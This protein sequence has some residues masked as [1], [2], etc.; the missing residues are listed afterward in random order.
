MHNGIIHI[1][2]NRGQESDGYYL[3]GNHK[4]IFIEANPFVMPT[5]IKK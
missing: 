1:G 2:A 4:V 5:L 3:Q